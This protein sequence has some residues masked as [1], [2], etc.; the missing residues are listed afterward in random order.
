M[1]KIIRK[2][3]VFDYFSIGLSLIISKLISRSARLIRYP[4][5]IRGRKHIDFGSK[6]TTGK[7]C[8]IEAFATNKDTSK[9]KIIFGNN[10]QINDC[11]HISALKNVRIGD[12]VLIASHV[13]ISDNSH[14]NYSGSPYDTS[15]N[16]PPKDREY[17]V[18]PVIIGNNVWIA[19]GVIIMPGVNIGDGSIIGAHSVVNKD[20]P[21][22]SIVVGSPA[23]V[24]KYY[25]YDEKCWIKS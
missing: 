16:I 18:K 7:Y 14:G 15:P 1:Y 5:V 13:Y 17:I 8:R 12:N 6:L 19:E 20:V 11:V 22:N 24:I 10:I 2:Y 4:I 23:R 21:S 9:V 3:S 25:S